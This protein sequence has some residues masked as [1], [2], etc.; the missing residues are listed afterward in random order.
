MLTIDIARDF[1]ETPAGRTEDD[2]PDSGER[3]RDK[4]LIPN[5]EK[6]T[7][8]NPLIVSIDGLEG[9]ASSFLEE[10]FGGVIR[11]TNHTYAGLREVLKI[12]AEPENHIYRN[13]I[14]RHIERE[15]KRSKRY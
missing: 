8:R 2:G 6:A 3:F 13:I 1:S 10:A 7:R 5:L 9:Y 15:A 4:F 12:K 11:K 14:W